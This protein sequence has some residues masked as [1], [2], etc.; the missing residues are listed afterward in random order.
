MRR[1]RVGLPVDA[2]GV[3]LEQDGDAVSGARATSVVGTP[4]LSYR[5]TVSAG[6][7]V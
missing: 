6:V 5:E 7:L 3:D 4:E 1:L 2:V